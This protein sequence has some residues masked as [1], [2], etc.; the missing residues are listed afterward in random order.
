[1]DIQPRQP[2]SRADH[3][4]TTSAYASVNNAKTAPLSQPE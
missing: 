1:M 4:Y 2:I 3:A